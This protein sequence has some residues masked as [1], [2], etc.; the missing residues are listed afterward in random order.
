MTGR[1]G[2]GGVAGGG[3]RGAGKEAVHGLVSQSVR[4][5]GRWGS[6]EP[7]FSVGGGASRKI[8]GRAGQDGGGGWGG[9]GGGGWGG[10]G[11][12]GV[13]SSALPASSGV[14][15]LD[16][17]Q[18]QDAVV[19]GV[20]GL[21]VAPRSGSSNDRGQE[22]MCVCVLVCMWGGPQGQIQDQTCFAINTQQ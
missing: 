21:Q 16:G 8:G 9:G 17:G 22:S 20:D 5:S 6:G 10:G 18:R 13:N 11:E 4:W 2:G 19:V 3:G 12:G 1:G 15:G 7:L 14:G